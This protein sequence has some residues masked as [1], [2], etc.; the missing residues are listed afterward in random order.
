MNQTD[1]MEEQFYQQVQGGGWTRKM[2]ACQVEVMYFLT[3]PP[4]M[5]KLTSHLLSTDL[6]NLVNS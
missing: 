2:T 5:T 1:F 4:Q 6:D 3:F